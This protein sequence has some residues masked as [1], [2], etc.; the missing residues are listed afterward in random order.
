MV[1]NKKNVVA[2][3][4]LVILLTATVVSEAQV[5]PGFPNFLGGDYMACG[6]WGG[7]YPFY[8]SVGVRKYINSFTSY[9]FPGI[10]PTVFNPIS[11]LEWPWEQLFGV[12]RLGKGSGDIQFTLEVAAT[13]DTF[14][15]LKAQDSDWI[16]PGDPNQKS[17][18]S[19]GKAKPRGW[20]FDGS[21]S[22]PVPGL[23]SVRAVAGYRAQQW[24]FS[25]TDAT[26]FQAFDDTGPVVV[27]PLFLPGIGIEFSEYYKMLYGGG[28]LTLGA[29]L[30]RV[31]PRLASV[32]L[33]FTGQG[34]FAGVRGWNIDWHVLRVPGPRYTKELTT[35]WAW[36][37]NLTVG[38]LVNNRFALTVEGDMIRIRTG[39]SHHWTQPGT[40]LTWQGARV[41]SDQ[42]YVSAS[43]IF[44]F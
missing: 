3:V 40:D 41:W 35:G 17:V 2:L 5:F 15:N 14:S 25:Y 6:T 8:G 4:A 11:R 37:V 13:L 24:K 27:P 16:W 26:Q 9:Q 36:H 28:I 12:V 30:G 38:C 43:G 20:T 7:P 19:E 21:L 1:K 44:T 31:S 29:G 34:D 42:K 39:G 22:Y 10:P 23:S 32:Q 33:M 18:F